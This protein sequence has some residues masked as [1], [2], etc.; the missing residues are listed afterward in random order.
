[1]DP[2]SPSLPDLAVIILTYNE[3]ENIAQALRSVCGWA[4]QV[5]VFD[6]HSTDRTLEIAK[7]FD[8]SIAQHP[9]EDYGR[10]RNAALD[11]LPITAEWVFFLDA[12]EWVPP[13]LQNE[14]TQI[15]ST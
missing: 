8:C 2:K 15:L 10:Q 14:I 3:E 6:S 13:E 5:F 1:M 11:T 12:D 4:K 9:F 7:T